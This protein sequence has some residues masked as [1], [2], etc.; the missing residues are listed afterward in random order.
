MRRKSVSASQLAKMGLCETALSFELRGTTVERPELT[1][2][3][4]RGTQ[5]HEQRHADLMGVSFPVDERRPGSGRWLGWVLLLAIG[6][7][8]VWRWL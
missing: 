2:A 4:A 6:A 3:A 7:W 5:R 8:A 1:E